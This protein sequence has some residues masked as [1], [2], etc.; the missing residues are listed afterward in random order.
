MKSAY[1]S[2]N[3]LFQQAFADAKNRIRQ[4]ELG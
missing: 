1:I 3:P 4:M 2:Q